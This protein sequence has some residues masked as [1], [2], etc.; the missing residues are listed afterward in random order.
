MCV[1]EKNREEPGFLFVGLGASAGG[2]EAFRQFLR[3]PTDDMSMAFFLLLHMG[4][5]KSMLTEIL[6]RDTS[7]PVLEAQ[8]GMRAE[9]GTIYVMPSG[10]D[11][12]IKD[13][14]LHLG[15]RGAGAARHLPIDTFF[16]SL[17]EDQ[18]PQPS[19]SS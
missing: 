16:R 6:S 19:G 17:A 7:L 15:P 11:M 14:V 1:P 18:G 4:E 9:R 10:H 13:G 12:T 5:A 3:P 8:D 2:V